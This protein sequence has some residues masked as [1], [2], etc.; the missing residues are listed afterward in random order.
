MK[1]ESFRKLWLKKARKGSKEGI[2]KI[3]AYLKQNEFYQKWKEKCKLGGDKSYRNKLGFHSCSK[4]KRKIWS[5]IGLKRTGR[6]LIGPH[7]EKMYNK[8]EL[9]VAK[10]ISDLGLR[11]EYEKIIKVDNKNGFV[12]IDFVIDKLPNLVIEVTYWSNAKEKMKELS[13]KLKLIKKRKPKTK[14]IV[15]TYDRYLDKYIKVSEKNIK[16]LNLNN[17]RRFLQASGVMKTLRVAWRNL[18]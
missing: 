5:M 4:E 17:F 9:S 3:R 1:D 18:L 16:V 6:K 13:K 8:L 10:I 11:Y 14:M 15:I 2:K 12:S 7:G